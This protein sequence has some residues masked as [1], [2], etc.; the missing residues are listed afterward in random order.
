MEFE[1]QD[2]DHFKYDVE[3]QSF[4]EEQNETSRLTWYH[5]LYW[6][7]SSIFEWSSIEPIP[8]EK[9]THGHW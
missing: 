8:P 7:R 3:V 2:K 1:K 9:Q 5:P 4:H 6:L